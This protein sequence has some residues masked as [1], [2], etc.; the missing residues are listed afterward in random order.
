MKKIIVKKTLNLGKIAYYG[1]RKINPVEIDIE[2]RECGGEPTYRNGAFCGYTPTYTELSICGSIWNSRHT[3]CWSAGQNIDTIAEYIHTPQMQAIQAMWK[4]F[5]LNGAHAGTEEQESAVKKYFAETGKRY[6][7]TEACEYLKQIGKYEVEYTGK[8]VG[9]MYD[10]EPYKYGH[11]WLV[12]DLP[13]YVIEW[14][15]GV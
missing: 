5:H 4:K 10:H 1:N 11:A 7:Y 12:R 8:T 3:D 9:R 15:K 2:I 14:A 6:D 13:E